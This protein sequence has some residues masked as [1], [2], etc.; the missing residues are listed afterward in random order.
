M[1]KINDTQ[2]RS[3][4]ENTPMYYTDSSKVVKIK[5]I[6][7]NVLNVFLFLLKTYIVGTR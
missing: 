2:T 5:N 1:Q 6:H 7:R 4:Y 3:H